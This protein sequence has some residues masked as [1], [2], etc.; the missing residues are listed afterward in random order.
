MPINA[1]PGYMK[2]ELEYQAATTL[3]EKLAG[4][5]RMLKECPKHKGSEN[6]VADIKRKISRLLKQIEKQKQIA[7]RS[8]RASTGIKK[9]GAARICII[10][11]PNSGKSTFLSKIT[12][13]KPQI[14][15]YPFTTKKPEVGTLDYEGVKIQ[16]IEIPAIVENFRDTEKGNYYASLI[17]DSDV[18]VAMFK[19][20]EE[21]ILVLREIKR[22]DLK[23]PLIEYNFL[24]G[25]DVKFVVEELWKN[26]GIIKVY[27][28]QP[29]KKKDFPPVA[30]RRGSTVRELA[31]KVHKD[32]VKNFKF[33]RV[34][35]SSAKFKGQQVGLMHV[36]KDNDVVE[37]HVRD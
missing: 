25:K 13:A 3:E 8:G 24:E 32:F 20:E 30:L 36:L 15:D 7:K 21:R 23:L 22:I 16:V 4:L 37:I 1:G 27:T 29:H 28:K 26:L 19:N 17:R 11:S 9:E 5:R 35:G 14:E 12:N 10:G 6:L 34:F 31:A 33:A 2:A 18:G